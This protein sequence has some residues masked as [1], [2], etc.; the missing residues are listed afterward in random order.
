MRRD[1]RLEPSP[2][3]GVNGHEEPLA[4]PDDAAGLPPLGVEHEHRLEPRVRP[5][6]ADGSRGHRG[7]EHANVVVSAQEASLD[8]WSPL[9]DHPAIAVLAHHAATRG[10]RARVGLGAAR[11]LG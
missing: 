10:T 1:V 11:Q 3:S 5:A 2:F 4:L 8:L 6:H 9:L 7:D